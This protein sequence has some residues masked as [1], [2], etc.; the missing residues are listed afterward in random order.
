MD[1]YKITNLV[2]KKVYI[3]ITNNYLV[4][5]KYHK[6]NRVPTSK[7]YNKVLYS[8]FRKY[9]IENFKFELIQQNLSIE[10]GKKLEIK[11]IKELKT[12]SHEHGYNIT[13]GGD[14]TGS[15]GAKNR[16]ATLSEDQAKDIIT[17]RENN[18]LFSSV[19]KD[20]KH[21]LKRTGMESIW[22]GISW[23][24]LQP[25]TITKSHANRK[26]TVENI[27]EIRKLLQETNLSYAQIGKQFNAHAT[28]I[29][30]IKHNKVYKNVI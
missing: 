10:E 20:Y 24:H 30:Q 25:E 23:K 16:N 15:E 27:R 12:L 19:Y 2:N 4:R 11:L 1:V 3:G 14:H 9:G 6:R 26:L 13:K 5:W 17:R 29:S 28:T 21:L 22:L 7:E 18:E 8:A